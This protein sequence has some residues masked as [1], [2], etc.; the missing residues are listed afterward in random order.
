MFNRERCV[1]LLAALI[2]LLLSNTVLAGQTKDITVLFDLS[3]S[4][5][6]LTDTRFTQS[7]AEYVSGHIIELKKGD[8]VHLQSF[9]SLQSAANFEAQTLVVK[10]HG[11]KTM[12]RKV[13]RIMLGLPEHAQFQSSTNIVAWF[14]R[15]QPRCDEGSKVIVITDGLEASEYIPNINDWLN[16]KIS[17]PRPNEFVEVAGCDI[18]F[19]GLGVGLN[20]TQL[21][22]L[23]RQW[24]EYFHAAGAIFRGIAK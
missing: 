22:V 23:R 19:Y 11:Q 10:R 16:G 1:Q 21:T 20:D 14:G 15:N 5:P 6:F 3:G 17:L 18:T 4:N 2:T 8:K 12:Q 24:H 13:K 9:G 7:A